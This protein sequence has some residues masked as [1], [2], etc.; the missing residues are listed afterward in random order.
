MKIIYETAD[1]DSLKVIII[2]LLDR[3]LNNKGYR[4]SIVQERDFSPSKHVLEGKAVQLRLAGCGKL[5]N[6]KA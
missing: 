2:I 4:L 6:N 3:H 1:Q 5:P